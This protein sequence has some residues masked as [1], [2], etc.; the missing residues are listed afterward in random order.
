MFRNLYISLEKMDSSAQPKTSLSTLPDEIL[1]LIISRL[2][3]VDCVQTSVLS[4][5]WMYLYLERIDI[6]VNPIQ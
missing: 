5:R 4:K 1:I 3:L 2:P 6:D